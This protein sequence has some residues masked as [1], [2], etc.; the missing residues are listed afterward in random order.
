MFLGK[1]RSTLWDQV[2][3]WEDAFLDAVMLEREGMGMDQGPQEMIERF[4]L[5][6][7]LVQ[8]VW[9]MLI[10]ICFFFFSLGLGFFTMLHHRFHISSMELIVD[11]E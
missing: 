1:E 4:H 3:F 10:F 11:C 7:V 6:I 8:P 9:F 2:Q 5:A